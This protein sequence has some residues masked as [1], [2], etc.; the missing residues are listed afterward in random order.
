MML[1]QP[2]AT[3]LDLRDTAQGGKIYPVDPVAVANLRRILAEKGDGIQKKTAVSGPQRGIKRNAAGV[4]TDLAERAEKL[5]AL[6]EA[7]EAKTEE[8]VTV[9]ASK[10]SEAEI[11]ALYRRYVM[12]QISTA[13]LSKQADY[14]SA[15]IYR[16]FK[17]RNFPVRDRTGN[18]D[19]K[20]IAR[21]CE[22]L[23]VR[24][25]DVPQAGKVKKTPVLNTEQ[26]PTPA[27]PQGEE[28]AS[29]ILHVEQASTPA[30]PQGEREQE[31]LHEQLAALTALMEMAQAK[32]VSISG[33]IRLDLVAE[34]EL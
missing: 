29:L 4:D 19:K 26:A 21:L 28:N 16:L 13:G 6:R 20:Q 14:S 34:I 33:K 3:P 18:Y 10:M 24:P 31:G 15:Q 11:W 22:V 27:L 32:Q 12:E 30:L 25:G 23:G 5:K 8:A 9:K 7:A 2:I 1:S 17:S